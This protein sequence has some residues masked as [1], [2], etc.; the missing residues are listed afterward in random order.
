MGSPIGLGIIGG[1]VLGKPL[2]IA[3]STW[4]LTRFTRASLDEAVRWV[5]LL[6]VGALAGIGFTVSL[7]VG[8][9]SF[10][11]GSSAGD[12]AKVGVLVASVGAALVGAA[13]LA[14]RNRHYRRLAEAETEDRDADG[15]PDVF[16]GRGYS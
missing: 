8:E 13:I 10:G 7:L 1:L 4:M 15:I 3:A 11:V 2:G 6:G 5:D 12:A 16:E 14:P 9:L